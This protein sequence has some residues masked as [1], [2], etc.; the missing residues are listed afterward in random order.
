MAKLSPEV[1]RVCDN[2][3]E[4]KSYWHLSYS[5][6]DACV[7]YSEDKTSTHGESC[8]YYRVRAASTEECPVFIPMGVG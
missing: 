8:A 5:S 4:H 7:C 3:K 2:C 6:Q 1:M